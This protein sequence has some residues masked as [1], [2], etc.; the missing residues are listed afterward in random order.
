MSELC[1]I[2]YVAQAFGVSEARLLSWRDVGDGPAYTVIDGRV[3][4]PKGELYQWMEAWIQAKLSIA[5]VRH[6]A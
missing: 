4:Y 5:R 1:S 6:A 2:G 3:W